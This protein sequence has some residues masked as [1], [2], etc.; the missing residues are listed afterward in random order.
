MALF[1]NHSVANDG[2]KVFNVLLE[3]SCSN[4]ELYWSILGYDFEGIVFI[5]DSKERGRQDIAWCKSFGFL[6]G[7]YQAS[8]CGKVTIAVTKNSLP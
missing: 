2:E 1:L 7:C 3:L 5:N 6:H 8:R 4:G